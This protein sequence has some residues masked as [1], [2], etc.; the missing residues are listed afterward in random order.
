MLA[1]RPDLGRF[2][3]PIFLPAVRSDLARFELPL[4]F[5]C[6]L[7]ALILTA[8]AVVSCAL[9]LRATFCYSGRWLTARPPAYLGYYDLTSFH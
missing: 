4:C 8:G 2:R 7:D 5:A 6:W 1:L 3:A 9:A